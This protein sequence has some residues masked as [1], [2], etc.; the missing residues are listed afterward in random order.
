MDVPREADWLEIAILE[1][2]LHYCQIILTE[3]AFRWTVHHVRM[4]RYE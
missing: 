3:D 4:S 2:K 1:E